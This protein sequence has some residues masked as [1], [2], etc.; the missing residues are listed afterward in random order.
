MGEEPKYT[1]EG[2]GGSDMK[3]LMISLDSTLAMD[4][5]KVMG[6]TQD[7]HI[8]YGKYLSKLFIIVL[9]KKGQKLTVKRLSDNVIVYPTSSRRFLSL[10]DAYRI[11]K[12]ICRE[13]KIDVITTQDVFFTGV[14]GYLLKRKYDIPLNVQFHA[15]FL[16]NKYWIKESILNYILNVI[17]K[18]I[19]KRANSVRV[20]SSTI[21]QKII[22]FDI[23]KNEI[24]NIPTG[25]GININKF[26]DKD[27]N[28]IRNK[29]LTNKYD[30]LI[31]FIGRISKQKNLPNLLNAIYEVIKKHPNALFL[32]A[33]DGIE[34]SSLMKMSEELKIGNNV[35]FVGSVPYEEIPYYYA[36]CDLFVLPS[37]Y[38]G[39]AR[40]LEEAAASGRP[41][42][43]TNVSGA[44]DVVING[45]TGYIVEP[46]NPNK[47]AEKIL[48]V[49]D[50]RELAKG[51]GKKG[52]K[53][54]FEKYDRSK[55]VYEIID[56]W[57]RTK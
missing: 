55:N 51:M 19:V 1:R 10:W 46:E 39:T 2:T 7:R 54:V 38:E 56:M 4:K 25:G 37:N 40:V 21:E 22:K 18:F 53:Y 28:K 30:R 33:G 48:K 42:V 9:S 11:A 23:K 41:I 24:I 43:T 44:S 57:R 6:D 20:V 13:N 35:I 31:L 8:L 29:Y 26:M 50:D 12:N 49:I 52:Q 3:V 47:L 16:D 15:D 5:E 34:K 45:V 36:A 27:G 14:T 17:G 32:I